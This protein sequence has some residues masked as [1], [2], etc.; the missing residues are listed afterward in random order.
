MNHI[1]LWVDVYSWY[2]NPNDG[3]QRYAVLQGDQFTKPYPSGSAMV[4]SSECITLE[5]L[6]SGVTIKCAGCLNRVIRSLFIA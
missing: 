1:H 6:R 4:K 2:D 5:E 3:R